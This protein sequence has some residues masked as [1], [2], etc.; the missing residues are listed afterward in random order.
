MAQ[1][2]GSKTMMPLQLDNNTVFEPNT[3]GPGVPFLIDKE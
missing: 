2:G 3:K 1:S